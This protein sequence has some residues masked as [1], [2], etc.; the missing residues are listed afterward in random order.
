[1]SPETNQEPL[2]RLKEDID[3]EFGSFQKFKEEFID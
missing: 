3:K 2:D 1:M